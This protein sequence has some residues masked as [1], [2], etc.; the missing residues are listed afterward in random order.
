M[1]AE[2]GGQ[3]DGKL[4]GVGGWGIGQMYIFDCILGDYNLL[5]NL[6]L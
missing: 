5:S 1:D 3:V 2:G 4:W 6:T